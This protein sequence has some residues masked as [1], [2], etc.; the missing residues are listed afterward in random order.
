MVCF[1]PVLVAQVKPRMPS[2]RGSEPEL[3]AACP[4]GVSDSRIPVKAL[5]NQEPQLMSARTCGMPGTEK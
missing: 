4:A 5:E 2:S 3:M 1:W